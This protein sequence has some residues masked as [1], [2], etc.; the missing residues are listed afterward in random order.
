MMR[1]P[2]FKL[3]ALT[4]IVAAF[5]GWLALFRAVPVAVSIFPF[6]APFFVLL[7]FEMSLDDGRDR[8]ARALYCVYRWIGFTGI[9]AWA[10]QLAFG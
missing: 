9:A 8:E 6:G 5:S 10:L 7:L 2:Q 1:V 3:Q 4:P